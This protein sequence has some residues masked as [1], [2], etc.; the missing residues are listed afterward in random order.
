M[1]YSAFPLPPPFC[2]I[3]SHAGMGSCNVSS[4]IPFFCMNKSLILWEIFIHCIASHFKMHTLF[5]AK[6]SMYIPLYQIWSSKTLIKIIC[7]KMCMLELRDGY[8]VIILNYGNSTMICGQYNINKSKKKLKDLMVN[9]N[10]CR[11]FTS[12]AFYLFLK[13]VCFIAFDI[14]HL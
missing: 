1:Y 6:N 13:S 11:Q 7:F 10:Y 8:P 2:H 3:V 14:T 9:L 12:C 5:K 4:S